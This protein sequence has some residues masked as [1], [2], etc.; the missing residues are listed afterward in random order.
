MK[1][2]YTLAALVAFAF[3]AN[4]QIIDDNIDFYSLGDVSPQNT[5]WEVWPG[6]TDGQVTDAQSTTAGGNSVLIRDNG[7]D[8]LLLLLGDQSS[9]VYALSFNLYIPAGAT[10]FYNYQQVEADPGNQYNGQLFFGEV[11]SAP[12]GGAA[13][14]VTF[15]FNEATADYP[16]DTWFN[17]TQTIDLDASPTT[18]T[19][20]VDGVTVLD[21]E[22]YIATAGTEATQLG[23]IDFFSIDPNNEMY[24]DDIF[25]QEGAILGTND[26][27]ASN[28]SV[29]PNPVQDRLN[30]QSTNT[31]DAVVVYDVLGKVV[32]TATPGAVSPS[33][34]M[35]TLTSGAYLVNITINGSSKTVKV[36]K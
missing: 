35:S 29:Y 1:K 20:E 11:A 30:I 27:A 2:I 21:A 22:P 14:T 19:L 15:D 17:V 9:G 31:V 36:V 23:S 32:L 10:G 13:N 28:F 7:T 12:G 24:I 16:S 6:G 34:D 25:Y 3:S 4:A 18:I 33:I 26:F 8:D 5:Y